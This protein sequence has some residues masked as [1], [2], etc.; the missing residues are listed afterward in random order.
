MPTL[1]QSYAQPQQYQYG[2]QPQPQPYGEQQPYAQ[3]PQPQPYGGQQPYAQAPQQYQYGGQRQ[4]YAPAGYAVQPTAAVPATNGRIPAILLLLCSLALVASLFLPL[5]YD[6]TLAVS[7][8]DV[9]GKIAEGSTLDIP[10]AVGLFVA[11]PIVAGLSLIFSGMALWKRRQL[12]GA[13]D[14]I[15]GLLLFGFSGLLLLAAGISESEY[16]A[17]NIDTAFNAGSALWLMFAASSVMVVD[18]I[19]YLARKKAPR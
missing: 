2:G 7:I 8:V 16:Q 4:A 17:G 9:L 11:L 10:G 14:L 6:A 5:L 19:V 15:A 13:L 1:P 12:W 18:S 3:A